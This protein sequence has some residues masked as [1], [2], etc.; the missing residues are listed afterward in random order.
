MPKNAV[1]YPWRLNQEYVVDRKRMKKDPVDDG[2]V[3]SRKGDARKA[4]ARLK[5][6]SIRATIN[7]S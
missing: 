5:L 6:G 2:L 4:D 3:F 1:G 7:P